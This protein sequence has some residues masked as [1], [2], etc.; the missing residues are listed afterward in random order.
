MKMANPFL[1]SDLEIIDTQVTSSNGSFNP[2]LS[3]TIDC[4]SSEIENPFITNQNSG[5]TTNTNPFSF[6]GSDTANVSTDFFSS[7]TPDIDDNIHT[8]NNLFENIFSAPTTSIKTDNTTNVFFENFVDTGPIKPMS[9]AQT[10]ARSSIDHSSPFINSNINLF[11]VDSLEITSSREG[12]GTN[13]PKGVPPKRPPPPGVPPRPVLPPSKETKDLILSVTGTMEA[14][15]SHLLD[16]LQ[17]T[18]TPSPT[19]I[20]DL[21]SPSPTPDVF[22][23]LLGVDDLHKELEPH[24]VQE[25]NLL[26]DMEYDMMSV[27]PVLE[28]SQMVPIAPVRS[29]APN[30]LPVAPTAQIMSEPQT[31]SV[32]LASSSVQSAI[33]CATPPRPL[34]P[35]PPERPK[36]PPVLASVQDNIIDFSETPKRPPPSKQEAKSSDVSLPKFE[37]PVDILTTFTQ[38][39]HHVSEPELDFTSGPQP[40]LQVDNSNFN[41]SPAVTEENSTPVTFTSV[42]PPQSVTVKESEPVTPFHVIN[43]PIDLIESRTNNFEESQQIT[44]FSTSPFASTNIELE[45]TTCKTTK[46]KVE[47]STGVMDNSVF[48][49][50][51]SQKNDIFYNTDTSL[52]PTQTTNLFLQTETVVHTTPVVSA[53]PFN[54]F[55]EQVTVLK[56]T[57]DFDAFTAKFESAGFDDNKTSAVSSDP[58]DPFSS[59]GFGATINTGKYYHL[60]Y[61]YKM[62]IAE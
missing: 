7:I 9:T 32:L 48:S 3:N 6:T 44:L 42:F 61:R 30:I 37:E 26:G 35:R 53:Q 20:R 41:N 1:M 21:N 25:G 45:N 16:R 43:V 27:K 59:S 50:H 23:D 12:S 55:E 5:S 17:A 8:S 31:S 52:F 18:R 49:G 62:F 36:A 39:S 56:N 2:F 38:Q 24:K 28:P 29:S 58:F 14:T 46:P 57:D 34:P 15:S 51:T 10:S 19:P 47:S 33:S 60:E 40:A 22:G 54:I 11:G 4:S 13:T